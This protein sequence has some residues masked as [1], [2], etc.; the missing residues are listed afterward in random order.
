[1]YV[2]SEC[3]LPFF[4]R[5]AKYMK[6]LIRSIFLPGTLYSYSTHV[7]SKTGQSP[8]AAIELQVIINILNCKMSVTN[9]GV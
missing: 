1:M 3:F 8:D 4:C 6:S 9:E 2:M 7:A 5:K